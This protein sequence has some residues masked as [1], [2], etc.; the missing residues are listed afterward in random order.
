MEQT[1]SHVLKVQVFLF[2]QIMVQVGLQQTQIFQLLLL[3]HFLLLDQI[4]MPAQVIMEFI[5]RPIME[6][7][8]LLHRYREEILFLSNK[9]IINF[10]RA[11]GEKEFIIHLIMEILGVK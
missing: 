5:Y 10:M 2:Q 8:G 1:F 9:I 11:R 4:F 7:A 6:I 3:T